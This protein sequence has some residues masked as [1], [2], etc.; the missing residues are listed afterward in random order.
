MTT[1]VL[2]LIVPTFD[3]LLNIVTSTM[4]KVNTREK[5]LLTFSGFPLHYAMWPLAVILKTRNSHGLHLN[6]LKL[7]HCGHVVCST[8]RQTDRR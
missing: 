1:H 5:Q 7:L 6:K 8:D 4:A 2:R 3:E